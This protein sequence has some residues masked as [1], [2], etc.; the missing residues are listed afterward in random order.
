MCI[1]H[2]RIHGREIEFDLRV[3][4]R[5]MTFRQ[6]RRMRDF[7]GEGI[8][9]ARFEDRESWF[10]SAVDDDVGGL[11]METRGL[12]GS[13]HILDHRR[14]IVIEN[15]IRTKLGDVLMILLTRR[16][17]DRKTERFGRL[18]CEGSDAGSC[19]PDDDGLFVC[20][21]VFGREG[22]SNGRVGRQGREDGEREGGTLFECNVIWKGDDAFLLGQNVF[23]ERTEVW[24]SGLVEGGRERHDACSFDWCRGAD[25]GAAFGH[26][27]CYVGAEDCWVDGDRW[28]AVVALVEVDRVEGQGFDLDE[29]VIWAGL[30]SVTLFHDQ[31]CALLG[32]ESCE[33]L[34]HF[35]GSGGE[36]GSLGIGEAE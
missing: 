25:V 33:V 24:F 21:C 29:E 7:G 17:K 12:D 23:L 28:H 18:H 1:P 11:E 10:Q 26:D 14:G 13:D 16:S 35:E 27:S 8:V 9:L 6:H 32:C 34:A 2:H 20:G 36:S 30:G 3:L 31:R 5:R 15:V 19:A 4:E 22:N